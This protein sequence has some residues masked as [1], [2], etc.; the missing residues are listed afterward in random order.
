LFRKSSGDWIVAIRVSAH[1]GPASADAESGA[2]L[3]VDAWA[4][5]ELLPVFSEIGTPC[6]NLEMQAPRAVA[7]GM[8]THII[9]PEVTVRVADSVARVAGRREQEGNDKR[10]Q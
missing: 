3:I 4:D 9:E 2:D 7:Q 5:E 10:R 6:L 8:I 1:V